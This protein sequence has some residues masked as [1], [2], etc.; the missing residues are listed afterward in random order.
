[1]TDLVK[2]SLAP[3]AVLYS[4]R[5]I[6]SLLKL[7]YVVGMNTLTSSAN[8]LGHMVKRSEIQILSNSPFLSLAC[9]K[10]IK[11]YVEREKIRGESGQPCRT[12]LVMG[13]S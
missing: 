4:L 11:G 2:L 5:I 13:I 8:N 7:S 9:R 10:S 12:P 1:M 3:K 6:C